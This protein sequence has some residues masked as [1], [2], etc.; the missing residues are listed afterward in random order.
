MEFFFSISIKPGSHQRR[1]CKFKLLAFAFHP[2]HT[3]KMQVQGKCGRTLMLK[4]IRGIPKTV[5][6]MIP[7][8][9]DI[10]Q[11]QLTRY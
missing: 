1:K 3:L 9:V 7:G 2:V 10:V 11:L 5:F 4:C 8:E 6:E